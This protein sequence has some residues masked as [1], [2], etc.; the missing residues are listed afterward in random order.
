MVK[1]QETSRADREPST[2]ELR[3]ALNRKKAAAYIDTS[4]RSI[5]N[6]MANGSLPYVKLNARCV[7]FLVKDLDA[8]LQKNRVA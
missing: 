5:A 4:P 3:A 1:N 8:F 2:V 6:Y 7:R